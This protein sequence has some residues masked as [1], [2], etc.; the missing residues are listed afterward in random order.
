MK[1]GLFLTGGGARGAYQ[2]GVIKALAEIT[3]QHKMPFKVLS[4]TSTG[5]I[6]AAFIGAQADDFNKGARLLTRVWS[7]MTCQQVFQASNTALFC[8]VL[9]TLKETILNRV[10][11]E[12]QYLLDTEPLRHLIDEHIDLKALNRFIDQKIY[13]SFS[14]GSL[15]YHTTE[16]ITFFNSNTSLN[17]RARYRYRSQKTQITTDHVMASS[18]IPIFFPPIKIKDQFY[19]DGS[20]R[21]Y[22]PLRSLIELGADK[23]LIVSVKK[24]SQALPNTEVKPGRGISFGN[25]LGMVFNSIFLDGIEL[26]LEH[27]DIIN[28]NLSALTIEEQNKIPFR[29]I[30]T[31]LIRPSKDIGKMATRKYKTLPWMLRYLLGGLKARKQSSD[32]H[33]YLLFQAEYC[34]SL[35]QLGYEDTI[36]RK[37]EI[38]DFL[39]L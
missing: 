21:N 14:I 11:R 12:G 27:L 8:A 33:S 1:T 24:Q 2:A 28:H 20:L 9:R 16:S 26:D 15:N 3:P 18:A 19:G 13:D 39:E 4:G 29:K 31:L 22:H 17:E 23:L 7:Q 38:L 36:K 30:D 32:M 34:Q 5:A 37:S 35:I 6:N 25:I 10:P